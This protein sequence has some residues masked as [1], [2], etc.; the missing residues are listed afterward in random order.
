MNAA[1]SKSRCSRLWG[2]RLSGTRADGQIINCFIVVTTENCYTFTNPVPTTKSTEK[3]KIIHSLWLFSCLIRDTGYP[4][5]HIMTVTCNLLLYI[6]NMNKAPR[7]FRLLVRLHTT[8]KKAEKSKEGRNNNVLVAL[9]RYQSLPWPVHL[10]IGATLL[11]KH[12]NALIKSSWEF[13][14]EFDEIPDK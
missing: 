11:R 9:P 3:N 13:K 10:P 4:Y 7:K 8:S 14:Q 12:R 2:C 6:F 5:I 1:V